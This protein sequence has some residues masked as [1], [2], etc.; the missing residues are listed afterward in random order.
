MIDLS[1]M[2]AFFAFYLLEIFIGGLASSFMPML[3]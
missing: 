1:P 3:G 2:I